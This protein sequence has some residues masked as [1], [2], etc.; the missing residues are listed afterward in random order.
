MANLIDTTYFIRDVS[1]PVDEISADLTSY[2]NTYE[3]EILTK[4]LGYELYDNFITAL[5]G[6]PG[7]EWTNLRDGC[8]YEVG[9]LTYKWRGFINTKKE[10]IIANYVWYNYV[11]NSDYYQSGFRKSNTE[12]SILVNPRPKQVKVYNQMVDWVNELNE[13]ITNNLSSYA[14]YLPEMSFSKINT[15]N[16]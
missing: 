15:F 13:F 10:S 11:C 3:P 7:T 8:E 1:L 6:T 2:I 12:N 14:N 4:I 9:S 5:A 16:I